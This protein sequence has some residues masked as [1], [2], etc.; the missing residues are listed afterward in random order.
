MVK[1]YYDKTGDLEFVREALPMLEREYR[2]W[3]TEGQHAVRVRDPTGTKR[4]GF[5][6]NRYFVSSDVARPEGWREVG[7]FLECNIQCRSSFLFCLTGATEGFRKTNR[8]L[9]VVY[10]HSC[11]LV[12]LLLFQENT[13]HVTLSER[14][15]DM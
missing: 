11:L 5:L 14:I 13:Q 8:G 6:L 12:R 2:F 9:F 4:S 15:F 10:K 3:M 1:S 7:A